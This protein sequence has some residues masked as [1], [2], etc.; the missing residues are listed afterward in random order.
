MRENKLRQWGMR[1]NE[2]DRKQINS[3][4]KRLGVKESEAVRR[5]VAYLLAEKPVKTVSPPRR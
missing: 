4:A 1:V 3:L 2:K 5:A